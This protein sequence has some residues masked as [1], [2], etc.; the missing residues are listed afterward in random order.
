MSYFMRFESGYNRF[1]IMSESLEKIESRF[2]I[3]IELLVDMF[4]YLRRIEINKLR[5]TSRNY[6][7]VINGN[8]LNLSLKFPISGNSYRL[9][10][11]ETSIDINLLAI[12]YM[13]GEPLDDL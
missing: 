11:H 2:P 12:G 10:K 1:E 4:S 8:L 7:R 9:P 6:N 3:P 13:N 5:E